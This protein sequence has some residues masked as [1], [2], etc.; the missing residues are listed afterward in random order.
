VIDADV[1]HARAKRRKAIQAR[2]L[3]DEAASMPSTL[4]DWLV[5]ALT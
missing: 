3:A 5:G 2:Q 1:Q 4:E